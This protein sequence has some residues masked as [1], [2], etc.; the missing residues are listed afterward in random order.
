MKISKKSKS[1][2]SK[3]RIAGIALLVLAL[4]GVAAFLLWQRSQTSNTATTK[5]GQN[6]PDSFNK[7]DNTPADSI[8][9][10]YNDGI[11]KDLPD[12][13]TQPEQSSNASIT[14][15]DAA[16]YDTSIEIRALING[17]IETDGTCT[18]TLTGPGATVTKT[19]NVVSAPSYTQCQNISIPVDNFSLKGSWTLVVS[20]Q[21]PHSTAKSSQKNVEIQ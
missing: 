10:T 11:K 17:V 19:A 21:S 12:A 2:F 4:V 8:D 6:G 14:I 5:V 15:V 9:K 1:S 7:I 18:A 3:K 13:S 16:Q 20:Y